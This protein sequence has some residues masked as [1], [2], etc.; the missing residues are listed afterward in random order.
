MD[1]NA[2]SLDIWLIAVILDISMLSIERYW[3]NVYG[4]NKE[5]N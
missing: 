5:V 1:I 3:L 2:F 4:V